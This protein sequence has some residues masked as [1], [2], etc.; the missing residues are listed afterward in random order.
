MKVCAAKFRLHDARSYKLGF[1][2]AMGAFAIGEPTYLYGLGIRGINAVK[3]SWLDDDTFLIERSILGLGQVQQW[4]LLFDGE[5]LHFRTKL[6]T[7]SEISIDGTT[8]G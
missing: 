7:G 1:L 5:K 6:G 8:G 3:G 4:T 2:P